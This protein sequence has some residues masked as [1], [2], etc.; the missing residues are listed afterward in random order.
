MKKKTY[1]GACWAVLSKFCIIY[2]FPKNK[3]R[4]FLKYLLLFGW[5]NLKRRKV[6]FKKNINLL[7]KLSHQFWNLKISL[8]SS[9]LNSKNL[10]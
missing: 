5:K 7:F 9:H 2:I 4:K 3:E 8:L 10:Y 1:G 6:D